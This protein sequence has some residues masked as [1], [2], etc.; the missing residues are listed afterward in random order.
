MFFALLSSFFPLLLI[1]GI[2]A[3]IVAAQRRGDDAL[4]EGDEGI[5]TVRRVFVYGLGLA[6]LGTGGTGVSLLLGGLFDAVLGDTVIAQSDDELAIGLSL[7]IVGGVAWLLLWRYAVGSVREHEAAER[8]S[9]ARHAYFALAQGIALVIVITSVATIGNWLVGVEDF[10]GNA[11]G[12][13]LAWLGVWAFHRQQL[14]RTPPLGQGAVG[15][16]RFY[17]YFAVATGLGLLAWGAWSV[18]NEAL[19][20]AYDALFQ[21]DVTLDRGD[22]LSRAARSSAV[23]AI[24]GGVVWWWH[25][26]RDAHTDARSTLWRVYVFLGGLLGGIATA[27]VAA[28]TLLH[29]VLQWLVGVPAEASAAAHFEDAPGA[30][31]ALVVG[32]LVWG[33]H[34]AVLAER[35]ATS[36]QP[37]SETERVYR[38]LAAAAGLVTLVAGLATLLATSIDLLVPDEA[39]LFRSEGWWRNSLVTAATLLVVGVPLWWR[40]WSDVQRHA[41]AGGAPERLALS[42]RT[43]VYGVFGVSAAMTLVTLSIVLYQ[44]FDALLSGTFGGDVLEDA[45]WPLALLLSAVGVSA[46][47][48]GVLRDDQ[49][50]AGSAP[51]TREV[52]RRDLL[53]VVAGD[54]SELARRLEGRAPVRV[55]TWRRTD[56]AGGALDDAAFEALLAQLDAVEGERVLVVLGP[57]GAEVVPYA[58]G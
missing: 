55:R 11:A 49:Q 12:F 29:R 36:E 32:V 6:A 34:R 52:A 38:Y 47:Y 5:G 7:S 4:D 54:A 58:T 42:R 2:V 44:V 1:G 28:S 35:A 39:A 56:A 46:Y 21:G 17:T 23:L 27:I 19:R 10:E 15:L 57:S 53:L 41:E 20:G 26:L 45:R 50:V 3:A 8:R 40:Y 43:F 51:V 18:A 33:Y 14:D 9:L 24:V 30:F 16:A 25:W 22:A 48:L 31:A 13:A 37:S